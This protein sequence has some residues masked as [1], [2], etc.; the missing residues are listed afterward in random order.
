[1]RNALWPSLA[2]AAALLSACADSASLDNAAARPDVAR[3]AQALEDFNPL[4]S[5]FTYTAR[6]RFEVELLLDPILARIK[7]RPDTNPLP[8]FWG[9]HS[10]VLD[11]TGCPSVDSGSYEYAWRVDGTQRPETGCQSA[12]SFLTT[13]AHTVELSIRAADGR[14]RSYHRTIP[15]KDYLI[16]SLGDSYG[17]GEGAP[18]IE[19]SDYGS[20]GWADRR[21]HRSSFAPSAIAA[22]QLEEADPLSS[23][24][25]VNLAC[26]GATISRETWVQDGHDDGFAWK[27][28]S[29]GVGLL[30]EYKGAEVH[31]DNGTKLPP[32]L[33][34][35]TDLVGAKGSYGSRP[36]DM[37]VMSAGGNDFGFGDVLTFCT[38]NVNCH[39]GDDGSRLR[40][41]MGKLRD[42]L[43]GRYAALQARLDTLPVKSTYLMEYP[44]FIHQDEATL[45]G[46]ILQDTNI[47]GYDI[48]WGELSFLDSFASRPLM[49]LMKGA[50]SAHGWNYVGGNSRAFIQGH[51]MCT[52]ERWVN[53]NTDAKAKQGVLPDDS[54]AFGFLST[55][56]VSMG[57]AHPNRAGYTA[58]AQNLLRNLA[59]TD[60]ARA[61]DGTLLRAYDTDDVYLIVG[62]A[63]FQVPSWEWLSANW[64]RGGDDVI[65]LP[66]AT[67]ER[68][69][70]APRDGTVV[71]QAGNSGIFVFQGGAPFWFPSWE[72]WAGYRDAQQL[73]DVAIK[74]VPG[75]SLE[76][77]RDPRD[78][79]LV[80]ER[81]SPA[82]WVYRG[83]SPFW[84]P[85]WEAWTAYRDALGLKDD[86]IRAVPRGSLRATCNLSG[87]FSKEL[88]PRDGTVV[89][90]MGKPAL[91]VYQGGGR[92]WVPSG[93]AWAAYCNSTGLT[94][95][96]IG[97]IPRGSLSAT[98]EVING[99]E[100]WRVREDVA[101]DGT[102]VREVGSNAMWVYQGGGRF[103]VPSSA[104]WSGY[105]AATGTLSESIR[106]VP[107]GS[108]WETLVDVNGTDQWRVRE[109][110]PRDGTVVRQVNDPAI[111]IYQGGGNFWFPSSEELA[112]WGAAAQPIRTIPEASIGQTLTRI[113]GV[114]AWRQ[115]N[116]LPRDGTLLRERTGSQVYRVQGGQKYPVGS[117]EASQV[118]VVPNGSSGRVPNT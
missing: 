96:A 21:C 93:E 115:R 41:E 102:V 67:L 2:A 116:D 28:I 69:L 106:T 71:R 78:G 62:G 55:S 4:P 65:D 48:S 39:E 72:E 51:G 24:T 49:D 5:G 61:A 74:T 111:F 50:A 42:A 54:T 81:T 11:F 83:G 63:R 100:Q 64:G 22:R 89:R 12:F 18:D 112:A 47:V 13:G 20:A 104:A 26:S 46:K 94:D 27:G 45:C 97:V 30:A 6:S 70:D 101:R 113:D 15:V 85:S 3:N 73:T 95:A 56:A 1:M 9:D 25:Y 14:T 60:P 40:F 36:I 110:V 98:L 23:V 68:F 35:L 10:Y 118:K 31:S 88:A 99:A 38:T 57:A 17:S 80:R 82:V 79:T 44:D 8:G 114:E 108:L 91:W 52:A 53:T 84:F 107:R 33:D 103:W 109:D 77:F 59:A 105:S 66:M 16:V 58:M 7:V 32:Q 75:G 90:E 86:D 92:F 76:K 37:L 34:V 87:C 29:E 117:Y 19:S 43:P